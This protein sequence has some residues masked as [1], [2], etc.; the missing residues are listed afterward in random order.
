GGDPRQRRGTGGRRGSEGWV[1]Q[2]PDRDG[3]R[4]GEDGPRR[5]TI[6]GASASGLRENRV[7][8]ISRVPGRPSAS[9]TK[10]TSTGAR[11]AA[12][13]VARKVLKCQCSSVPTK[14]APY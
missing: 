1:R 4:L 8:I 5:K 6:D 9:S 2:R 14:A 3:E 7:P 12:F 13:H 11:Q 10:F